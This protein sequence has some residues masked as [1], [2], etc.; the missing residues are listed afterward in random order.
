MTKSMFAFSVA[1]PKAKGEVSNVPELTATVTKDK[2]RL[3]SALTRK[4][5]L[6]HG[7]RLMFISN[8]AAIID[9]IAAGQLTEEE[10]KEALVYAIAKSVPELDKNGKVRKAIRRL[11]KAEEELFAKGELATEVNEDGKPIEVAF[12]GFK[13]ASTS[14]T[15]G[16]GQILEGSDA[17]HWPALGGNENKHRVFRLGESTSI[18]VSGQEVT[19]YTLEF[20]REEEKAERKAAEGKAEGKVTVAGDDTDRD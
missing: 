16:Y 5:L 3:N 12:H 11:S 10:G 7:D 6:Q 2:I 18:E 4:L 17:T 8:E 1:T 19:V 13:L 9:A 20:D 15:V 14:G